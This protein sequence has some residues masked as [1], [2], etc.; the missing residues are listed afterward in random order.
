MGYHSVI[1]ARRQSVTLRPSKERIAIP[2]PEA[3]T[4]GQKIDNFVA[5]YPHKR[6]LVE[7]VLTALLESLEDSEA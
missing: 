6:K 3:Y 4:I 5:K 7:R 1:P 2:A